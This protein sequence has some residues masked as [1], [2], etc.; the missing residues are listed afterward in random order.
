MRQGLLDITAL[1]GLAALLY[2]VR[3]VYPPATWI[4]GGLLVLGYA[5]QAS[6]PPRG[7]P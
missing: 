6:R 7:E 5:L 1:L 4:L 3:Q 2:G